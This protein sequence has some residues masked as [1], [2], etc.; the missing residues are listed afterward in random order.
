M[1]FPDISLPRLTRPAI[2][3]LIA[4]GVLAAGTGAF[5]SWQTTQRP[6]AVPKAVAQKLLFPV[7]VPHSL[8]AGYQIDPDTFQSQAGVLLF[9]AKN[10][11]GEKFIFSEQAKPQDFDL[12]QF[13]QKSLS[14]TRSLSDVPFATIFG[15]A[16]QKTWLMSI[17]ADAT[18]VIVTTKSAHP[19]SDFEAIAKRLRKQ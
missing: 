5:I 9:V 11:D 16:D 8:P 14:N 3:G 6:P 12:G 13:Y 10:S 7:Y 15:Q 18:W 4:A 17:Q 1:K 19:E 2:A